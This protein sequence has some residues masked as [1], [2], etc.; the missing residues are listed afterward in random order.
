LF[1]L[2]GIACGGTNSNTLDSKVR[3][4]EPSQGWF[5]SGEFNFQLS[6][7]Y[8]LTQDTYHFDRY[9]HADHGW[10]GSIDAK[11]FLNRYL[12]I[13][14]EGYALSATQT[15]HLISIFGPF[16]TYPTLR[17][18]RVVGAGLVTLT[19]RCPI[20]DS[21]AAL[22]AFAGGGAIAGGGRH[23]QTEFVSFV[24]QP[25]GTSPFRNSFSEGSTEAVGQLG[26]GLEMRVSR[27]FGIVTDFS[28]NVVDGRDNNFGMARTGVNF[29]F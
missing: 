13:G 16:T 10:G 20:G 21:R 29:A 22:F 1:A 27:H 26:G 9:I 4:T 12:G 2:A 15:H 23:L 7:V 17:D 24:G 3:E 25:P 5:A 28:W 6:G 11:Y 8:A 14:L 19:L 18:E